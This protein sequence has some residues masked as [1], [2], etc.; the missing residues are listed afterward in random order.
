MGVISCKSFDPLLR[1]RDSRNPW[2]LNL[3]RLSFQTLFHFFSKHYDRQNYI[4]LQNP[5]KNWWRWDGCC[6]Q[7]PRYQ[8]RPFRRVEILPHHFS[9]EEEEKQRF[10]REAK[11]A[12]ALDHPNICNI[13]EI[14]ESEDGQMFIVMAYYEGETLKDKIA[15]EPLKADHAI[16]IALQVA[17]GENQRHLYPAGY[18]HSHRDFRTL[19]SKT[20]RLSNGRY[21]SWWQNSDSC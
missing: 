8:T 10:I 12:S 19:I 14:D 17:E 4:T 5:R 11:A 2:Q 1:L 13:H 6:V 20:W 7:S 21:S 18:W 15:K 9:A 16:D 3:T